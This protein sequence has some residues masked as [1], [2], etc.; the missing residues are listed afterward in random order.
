VPKLLLKFPLRLSPWGL[1]YLEE[2][3]HPPWIFSGVLDHSLD[4]SPFP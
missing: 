1:L 3:L 2:D 4:G